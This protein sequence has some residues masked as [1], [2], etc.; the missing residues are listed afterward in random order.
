MGIPGCYVSLIEHISVII[1]VC[2]L[3]GRP[4]GAGAVIN[5]FTCLFFSLRTCVAVLCA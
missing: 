3:Y 2:F 5:Y 1:S 4:L